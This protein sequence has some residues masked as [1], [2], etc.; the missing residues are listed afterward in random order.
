MTQAHFN[1]M[2]DLIRANSLQLTSYI[3]KYEDLAQAKEKVKSESG[4][5]FFCWK[6]INMSHTAVE[7]SQG[8]ENLVAMYVNLGSK[9][10]TRFADAQCNPRDEM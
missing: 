2:M 6:L 7:R 5:A 3:Y 9:A 4:N 10:L 8:F 1:K